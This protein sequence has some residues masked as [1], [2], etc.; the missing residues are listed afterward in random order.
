MKNRISLIALILFVGALTYSCKE[1]PPPPKSEEEQQIEKL[2]KT[3]VPKSGANAITVGGTDV[4]QNWSGFVLTLG[5]KTYQSTGADSPQVWP[6]SG[7][8]AFGSDVNTL[9]R[10]DGIEMSITVN[11]SS[12]RLQFDYTVTG[13]RLSGIEGQWVFDMVPQ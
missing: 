10:D 2:A 1:K 4:S 11:E 12:L 8:W 13:G 7:T 5:D 9:V 3:W 6:A